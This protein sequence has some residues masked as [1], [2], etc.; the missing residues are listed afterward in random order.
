MHYLTYWIHCLVGNVSKFWQYFDVQ[1]QKILLCG[2]M[3]YFNKTKVILE[4]LKRIIPIKCINDSMINIWT[5][6]LDKVRLLPLEYL[7]I[8]NL[9]SVGSLKEELKS[10]CFP[11]P[12]DPTFVNFYASDFTIWLWV[13]TQKFLSSL[14]F[15]SGTYQ[16][17][18]WQQLQFIS[19]L[20]ATNTRFLKIILIE[21]NTAKKGKNWF[22]YELGLHTSKIWFPMKHH[23]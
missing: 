3:T 14:D 11:N 8:W 22:T 12:N 9:M 17:K 13:N 6:N 16:H 18:K 21:C 5:K 2:L 1:K 19:D 20:S 23:N 10:L 4:L 15:L 7:C